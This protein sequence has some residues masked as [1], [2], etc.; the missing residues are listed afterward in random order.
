M[1]P[2]EVVEFD[3]FPVTYFITTNKVM[4]LAVL[5]DCFY[6][7]VLAFYGVGINTLVSQIYHSNL[8]PRGHSQPVVHF[9]R[10]LVSVVAKR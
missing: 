7:A 8:S 2:S 4:I 3:V 10:V 1:T 6:N 9:S 5:V